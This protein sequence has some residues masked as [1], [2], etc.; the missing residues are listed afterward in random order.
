MRIALAFAFVV[1]ATAPLL[2][3][4]WAHVWAD[5]NGMVLRSTVLRM[6]APEIEQNRRAA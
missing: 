1:M 5:L 2:G 6:T 4:F 3:I